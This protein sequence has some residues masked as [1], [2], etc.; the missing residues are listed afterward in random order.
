[1]LRDADVDVPL[2]DFGIPQAFLD[3]GKRPEVMADIGLS[4]QE[5]ARKVV[6]MVAGRASVLDEDAEESEEESAAGQ[7]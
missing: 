5:L 1:M 6:E 4:A 7:L 3:Q 2:R